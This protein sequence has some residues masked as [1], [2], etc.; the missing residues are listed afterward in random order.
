MQSSLTS[1]EPGA[2]GFE[3]VPGYLTPSGMAKIVVHLRDR[4]RMRS[5]GSVFCDIGCGEG[6]AV[7]AAME[8]CPRLGGAIGF[9]VDGITLRVAERNLDRFRALVWDAQQEKYVKQLSTVSPNDDNPTSPP[10]C[11][12]QRDVTRLHD[13]GCVT[14]AYTFCNGM[15][16]QVLR[17]VIRVC[18]N[19]SSLR[20]VVIVYKKLAG[21]V[22]YELVKQIRDTNPRAIHFFVDNA[23]SGQSL[24]R[25]PGQV[26][27][28]CCIRMNAKGVGEIFASTAATTLVSSLDQTLGACFTDASKSSIRRTGR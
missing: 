24:L 26:A 28:G 12:L 21:D 4:G 7:L 19:T 16:E 9:D 3:G 22:A 15:P 14:H 10:A 23:K 6:R 2:S 17:H 20:Y 8:A 27:H 13:L 11:I 18:V 25:M 1:I 5:N